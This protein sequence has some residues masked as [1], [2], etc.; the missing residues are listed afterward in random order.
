[1]G[2]TRSDGSFEIVGLQPGPVD[3][4]ASVRGLGEARASVVLVAGETTT[5][6]AEIRPAK[7][8]AGS[9]VDESGDPLAGVSVSAT[10]ED[11]ANQPHHLESTVT[12]EDGRFRIPGA[13]CPRYTLSV[14]ETGP[15][16][17]TPLE[18]T[19]VA[20]G[21]EVEFVLGTLQ[22]ASAGLTGRLL[23]PDGSPFE[24]KE[25][26]L[27][28]ATRDGIPVSGGRQSTCVDGQLMT[29]LVPPGAFTLVVTREGY[30]WTVG[31]FEVVAGEVR[32]LGT[33]VCPAA[34][35]LELELVDTEGLTVPSA[36]FSLR[37]GTDVH[38][39][40]L[41]FKDGRAVRENVQ[42]GRYR[43]DSFGHDVPK[44]R[45][46]L[47]VLP[48]ETT[49]R[50]ITLPPALDRWLHF[51][52]PTTVPVIEC[53]HTWT[54][55]GVELARGRWTFRS[56]SASSPPYKHR[57]PPGHHTITFTADDGASETT[58]FDVSADTASPDLVVEVRAPFE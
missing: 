22:R 36:R 26:E 50:T 56:L 46:E 5:W 8:L 37:A 20:P 31:T 13:V 28:G 43:L 32:D 1:M 27:L 23:M 7:E 35:R 53:L 40:L 21:T 12:D 10:C 49:R 39:S 16:L 58:T 55:D 14:R 25:V 34:G 54:C 52:S 11:L 42:P 51:P 17:C 44:T 29:G 41:E 45:V 2:W 48:G 9:V 15:D 6:L 57:L 47:E 3:L 18:R 19:A 33:H 4:R 30:R 38:G 24:A